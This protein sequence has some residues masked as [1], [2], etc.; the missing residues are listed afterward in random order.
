MTLKKRFKNAIERGT[1]EA[2]LILM[3]NSNADFSNE[4]LYAATHHLAYDQQCERYRTD[5]LYEIINLSAHK[6]KITKAILRQLLYQKGDVYGLNQMCEIARVLAQDGNE[7]AREILYK[8]FQKNLK[9]N[10]KYCGNDSILALDGINGLLKIADLIGQILQL[11]PEDWEDG[12]REHY[13]QENN[14]DIDVYQTL[15]L[16]AKTNKYIKIYLDSIKKNK[17]LVKEVKKREP[18]TYGIIKERIETKTIKYIPSYISR[19]LDENGIKLLANDFLKEKD[20]EKIEIYLRIFSQ[21]K[22]PQDYTPILEIAKV[23]YTQ[24]NSLLFFAIKTLSRFKT[25]EIRKFALKKMATSKYNWRY[26]DLFIANYKKGIP[27][28][29]CK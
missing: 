21:V 13:F 8:R 19:E 22:F 26:L 7:K 18:F 2:Q 25:K 12:N 14:P 16:A 5:Y 24:K 28:S 10:Y 6:V 15:E 27:N 29:F 23:K 11:D 20:P 4:I 3:Q 9:P 17:E 1:G